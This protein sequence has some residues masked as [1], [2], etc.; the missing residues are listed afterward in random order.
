MCGPIRGTTTHMRSPRRARSTLILLT[1]AGFIACSGSDGDAAGPPDRSTTS[2]ATSASTTTAPEA[3]DPVEVPAAAEDFYTVPDPVPPGEHGDLV[4][5]QEIAPSP[6][7]ATQYRV[8][9]LSE[10]LG[11]EPIVVTGTVT[12]PG[13]DAPAG[14]WR[15]LAHAHGTTGIA[16]ECA[17]SRGLGGRNPGISAEVALL[18]AT[19]PPRGYVVA[20]TDYEGLGTPGRHPYLVGESEGRSVLDAALAAQQIP[21]IE[22]GK[23]TVIAGYSQGGHGALWANEIAEEWAPDLE[24]MGTFAGAPASQLSVIAGV[25][26]GGG[27][28]G[29]FFLLAVAGYQAA[30]PQADPALILTP[31]GVAALDAVD[32]GCVGA[33]LAKLGGPGLFKANPNDV[34]PWS[35]LLE[36]N[37]PGGTATDAP[38]L[39][40]HSAKDDVVPIAFSQLLLDRQCGVDQV[41]ERR[42]LPEGGHVGAAPG[43]YQQALDWFDDRLAA[44]DPVSSCPTG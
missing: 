20:S 3:V 1:V 30:Y 15:L 40:V 31:A 26:P 5:Y 12:V 16:D 14:G 13:G 11:D 38:V 36:E 32:S 23:E 34:E 43:A 33:V 2:P 6:A 27:L 44:E 7:G 42:V 22:V 24:V 4:R 21:G 19:A 9:Y 10:T 39:V 17:P 28:A 41:V 25:A 35:T 29:G 18:A 37:E 8:M